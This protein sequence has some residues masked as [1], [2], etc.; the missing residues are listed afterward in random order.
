MSLEV[1][2]LENVGV[3]VLGFD[4]SAPVNTAL[5]DELVALWNAH[6]ILLF[7]GQHGGPQQQIEFSRLFGSLARHP[8][9]VT[10]SAKYPE[11]FELENGGERDAVQTAGYNGRML[12][13][14]LDWHMDLHYTGRPN[15][16]ALLRA[17]TVPESGGL[18]GFG[19]LA[20]AYDALDAALR[21]RIEGLQVAYKFE[22]QRLKMRFVDNRGYTPGPGSP[23]KP[24]DAGFPD[25]PDS[26][27]PLVVKHPV[28]GRRVLEVV[29]LFLDRVVAP[30]RHGLSEADAE[31]LLH[32]LVDHI[33][34]PEF[35]YF[36]QWR[37]G[38]MILWDNWRA[39]HCATGTEPGVHRLIHRTTI[40][41][42][43][44]LGRPLP[45]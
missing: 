5:K 17:V 45:G 40:E 15:R 13:N 32:E 6:A 12:V 20:K 26:V 23:K 22:M 25:F 11:L 14:K 8:L 18:T 39:M 33:R 31:H 16:G 28:T 21:R 3:E 29:E 30:E 34:R 41:G 19:D 7:R 44:A 38:D 42:D 43:V 4:I 27:Y 10:R 24:A 37:E 36:H 35:H 2:P 1:R 9:E